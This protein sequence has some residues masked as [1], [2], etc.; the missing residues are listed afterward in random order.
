MILSS[1]SSEFN[2]GFFDLDTPFNYNE[3][4]KNVISLSS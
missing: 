3:T 2:R 4:M 1:V